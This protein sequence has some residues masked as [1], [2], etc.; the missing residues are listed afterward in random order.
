M[1]SAK[2]EIVFWLLCGVIAILI[3]V[4][5]LYVP[6]VIGVTTI[7]GLVNWAPKNRLNSM[8]VCMLGYYALVAF[9]LLFSEDYMAAAKQLELKLSLVIFP[10]LFLLAPA[11]NS[12]WVRRIFLGFALATM[13][14]IGYSLVNAF[15]DYSITG[16]PREFS[17]RELAL[18]YHPTY[19]AAYCCFTALILLL[20]SPQTGIGRILGGVAYILIA[21]FVALLSSKAGWLCQGFILFFF[22]VLAWMR[23][24][25]GRLHFVW[26]GAALVAFSLALV[27]SPGSQRR[28]TEAVD[29]TQNI[30][31]HE[32]AN[33]SSSVRI[34]AWR[35]AI[36]I[37]ATNPFG[38][39]TD[40]VAQALVEEYSKRGE[41]FAEEKRLNAHNQYLQTGVE[42]GWFGLGLLLFL[43]WSMLKRAHEQ[44]NW[45]FLGFTLLILANMLFESFLELQQGIVFV[46]F[47]LVVFSL[48]ET[49]PSRAF[50]E[51]GD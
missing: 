46:A 7:V 22:L 39:G 34:V 43:L 31:S 14:F 13:G 18:N 36:H 45:L 20:K 26:Q 35:S 27:F 11:P 30:G 21:L 4:A 1:K 48:D 42:F 41:T 49:E 9:G 32:V 6:L 25:P 40:D 17:Y 12:V 44:R 2:L 37:I 47:M 16:N 15:V 10:C 50:S 23:K 29:S 8:I 38:V 51:N 28:L 19:V 24:G 33:S 3:P 5:K